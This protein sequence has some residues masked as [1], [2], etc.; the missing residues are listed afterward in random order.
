VSGV[1]EGDPYRPERRALVDL[2]QRRREIGPR[3]GPVVAEALDEQLGAALPVFGVE[4]GD[5]QRLR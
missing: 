3:I 5:A 4:A 1:V 2:L